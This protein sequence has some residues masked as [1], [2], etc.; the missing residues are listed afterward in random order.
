MIRPRNCMSDRVA[1]TFHFHPPPLEDVF[2]GATIII[3]QNGK[4]IILANDHHTFGY[5][6]KFH[7]TAGIP[8]NTI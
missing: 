8:I 6:Y 7:R 5:Q 3:L 4:S 1:G 2:K